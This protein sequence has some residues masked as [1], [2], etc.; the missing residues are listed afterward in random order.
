LIKHL[1]N[2]LHWY[3]IER[4]RA[5]KKKKRLELTRDI[6][7]YMDKISTL[8]NVSKNCVSTGF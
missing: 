4:R 5:E 2:R 3:R 7:S 6:P 1:K 8:F